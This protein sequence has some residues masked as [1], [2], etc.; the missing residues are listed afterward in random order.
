V[1]KNN[2]KY[3]NTYIFIK[4]IKMTSIKIAVICDDSKIINEQP[5]IKTCDN[6]KKHFYKCCKSFGSCL[7][8]LLVGLLYMGCVIIS[9]VILISII[10]G[11]FLA[12]LTAID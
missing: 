5:E 10:Y 4:K 6:I 1:N 8:Q 7:L 9:L 3:I 11:V 2:Y 12:V